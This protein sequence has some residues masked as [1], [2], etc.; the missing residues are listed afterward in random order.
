MKEIR[1][2]LR[3]ERGAS[4]TY[5][6]LLFLVCAV[7]GAVVL[8]AATSASGRLSGLAETDQRYYSV[9]S[10]AELIRD[11]YDG[12][13][14]VAVSEKITKTIT[15]YK[16]D[17][18]GMDPVEDSSEV[19][20]SIDGTKI[21][22]GYKPDTLIRDA[23]YQMHFADPAP[24]YP[25]RKELSLHEK[26][27]SAAFKGVSVSGEAAINEDGSLSVTIRSKSA[28]GSDSEQDEYAVRLLFTADEQT[29]EDDRT[30]EGTAQDTS[31]SGADYQITTTKTE[32]VTW[33]ITWK[34]KEMQTVTGGT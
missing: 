34:Y 4:I 12:A 11:L 23:A 15:P 14:A 3:S 32:T 6:L 25:L 5:A 27:S 18:S 31:I 1:K 7:V 26:S 2:K 8:V 24:A 20:R 19:N 30:E 29:V 10:A 22:P 9:T 13:Q 28:D 17:G 21:E 16:E 33:T